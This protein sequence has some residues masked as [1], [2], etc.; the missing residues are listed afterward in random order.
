MTCQC[1]HYKPLFSGMCN[2]VINVLRG[3][4]AGT[5]DFS[6]GAHVCVGVCICFYKDMKEKNKLAI[7]KQRMV[8]NG[9]KKVVID[10]RCSFD[11]A[12]T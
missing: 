3:L 8:R 6:L 7:F 1:F 11:A 5:C 9:E 12:R 10:C 2:P 4:S